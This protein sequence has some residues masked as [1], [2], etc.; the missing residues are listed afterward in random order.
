MDV[1]HWDNVKSNNRLANLRYGTDS[2]N[3]KDRIRLG[4]HPWLKDGK[5]NGNPKGKTG[6]RK[7]GF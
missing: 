2:D 5:M 3:M 7:R 1:L 6:K 4:T